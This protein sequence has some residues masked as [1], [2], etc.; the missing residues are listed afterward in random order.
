MSAK[1]HVVVEVLFVA[2]LASASGLG[3]CKS[4]TPAQTATP[5][6][7]RLGT[8]S[9]LSGP[10]APYGT[11]VVK[12]Q[13]MAVEEVNSAGGVL[14]R[15]IELVTADDACDPGA[16]V[17]AAN[18]LVGADIVVSVG[19]VCSSATV[20]TLKIF[21]DA[22]IPMIVPVA[23]STELLAAGYDSVFL[24]TGTVA[25]EAEFMLKAMKKVGSTK[26]AV[27]HDGTSFPETLAKATVD[28]ASAR[29]QHDITIIA[30]V[31]L[32]EGAPSQS[33]IAKEVIQGAP[34]TV[35]YTGYQPEC[36][37]LVV[38]LR[39]AGYTG[40]IVGGDGVSDDTALLKGLSERQT[41]DLYRVS[42]PDP[43][44]LPDLDPW[45]ARFKA[46]TRTTP[47]GFAVAGYDSVMLAVDAIRRAGSLDHAAIRQ[48]IANSR[49]IRLLTGNPQFKPDGSR[50][51]PNFLLLRTK[52]GRFQLAARSSDLTPPIK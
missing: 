26:M 15:Q 28:A 40:R 22:G 37:Q 34:D 25:A 50:V 5:G 17:L 42:V 12:A 13:Q 20:P 24:I 7:I 38:D 1:R 30:N 9:A 43:A 23:N 33:R 6:V 16:G 46:A 32:S 18:K 4:N 27:V 44:F 35:F 39:N 3:G 51:I 49:D 10:N 21:H 45:A 31:R 2:L 8:M 19:G 52:S 29:P 36:R 48:A 47:N 14:G 11:P 41:D